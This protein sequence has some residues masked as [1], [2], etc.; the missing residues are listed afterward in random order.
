MVDTIDDK[1]DGKALMNMFVDN[2]HHSL[3]L[4]H[5]NAMTEASDAG[6]ASSVPHIQ[7]PTWLL[8]DIKTKLEE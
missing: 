2:G 3:K 8:P 4:M 7:I 6:L 1:G 5:V